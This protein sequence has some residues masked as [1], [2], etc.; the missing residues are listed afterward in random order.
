MVVSALFRDSTWESRFM[1]TPRRCA[2][3]ALLAVALLAGCT[4]AGEQAAEA[5]PPAGDQ[6]AADAP[7]PRIVQ[8]GAPGEPSREV[9]AD[10]AAGAGD[11]PHTAADVAFMQGM[12]PHHAQALEMTAMVAERTERE[13]IPLFARRMD[14]SQEAEIEQIEA[15]LETR[16]EAA[17]GG[18][19]H[20]MSMDGM[21][22]PGMLTDDELAELEAAQG[23]E[24]DRLF[25]ESMIRHHEGALTMVEEL[26]EAGGGQETQAFQFANH[27]DSDQRIEITRMQ[28]MLADL[29]AG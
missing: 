14:I 12:L 29:D 17:S 3:A 15:W 1:F 10:E 22:M 26:F 2:P 24:F 7:A 23:Q 20:D 9:T 13:D 28:Q 4:S 25:L 8:P 27:V 6:D 18:A 5:V 11:T 19:D 21:S 16:D